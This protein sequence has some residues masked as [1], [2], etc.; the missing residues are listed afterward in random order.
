MRIIMPA[1]LFFATAYQIMAQEG[2]EPPAGGGGTIM[3]WLPMMLVMFA[4]VYF[5]MIRPEQKKQKDRRAMMEGIKKGDK[6]LSIGGIYGTV[7]TIKGNNLMVKIG[8][9]TTVEMTKA[10]VSSVVSDKGES[11]DQSREKKQ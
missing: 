1:L 7:T 4:I 2:Q 3:S 6:V 10:A 5:L 9:N 11:D 8:D